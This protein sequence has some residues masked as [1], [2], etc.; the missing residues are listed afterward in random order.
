MKEFRKIQRG[1]VMKG[2]KGEKQNLEIKSVKLLC[3]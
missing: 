3:E 2:L 1:P